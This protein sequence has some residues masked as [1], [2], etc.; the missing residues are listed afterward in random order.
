MLYAWKSKSDDS[1]VKI[2]T[3]NQTGFEKV[4]M[5]YQDLWYLIVQIFRPR[6]YDM[7]MNM[8]REKGERYGAKVYDQG[9]A[10]NLFKFVAGKLGYM[11]NRSVPWI[12]FESTDSKLMRRDHIKEYLNNA[13]E[14]ALFGVGRSTLYSA[15]VPHNMDAESVG[16]GVLVPM[17][18]EFKD[19]VVFDVVHP[20]EAYIGTDQFGDVNVFHRCPLK[21]TRMKAQ[22]LFGK[23][24]LP[25]TWYNEDGELKALVHEDK[26]IWAVY[27]NEDRNNN[28]K[29]ATDNRY[30][31]FCI[32]KGGG[33]QKSKLVYKSGRPYFPTC[34]RTGRESG[35]A[36][37]TSTAADCLTSALV[38]NK[39]GEK[40]VEAAHKAV[41]PAKIA[42]KSLQSALRT[43]HGGRAGSTIWADDI[44]KEGVKLF[45]DRLNWPVTDAQLVRIDEQM[46]DRMFIRFFEML[47]AGD[48]KSRT[49]Y[50]VSQMMAEKATL[51]STM[52]DTLEEE[53]LE[54]NI[55]IVVAEEARAGRMP[56]VPPE[57]VESKGK[58]SVRYLGPLAQLQRS[59]LR[60][61]GTI[62][63]LGI[64]EQMMAMNEKVGWVFN[65]QQMAEDVTIAQGLPQ[66]L[67]TSDEEQEAMERGVQ[68][69]QRMEQ[70]AQMLEVAGKA[71][72][73][74]GKAPEEGST[75]AEAI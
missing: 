71:S 11:V 51:M 56:P 63:A 41:D 15:L 5:H 14:Q 32:L 53:D 9:P 67:I 46:K 21:L 52:V 26:Y 13:A 12:Q 23:E 47:N 69:Q 72:P 55:A 39:L 31:V 1:I 3:G 29:L 16:T 70:Q 48:I 60:S 73:G 24:K 50:E 28:S 37:G 75:L 34:Y 18:D 6:R 49:A 27:P 33:R 68:E 57:L 38:T 74:L 66:R 22:L 65:W 62:D 59:L 40:G 54:P 45:Q 58:I 2:V 19:R 25:S 4:R 44:N 17:I 36:Y 7:L 61:R 43:A 30:I 8:D 64:I 42:S 35:A 10:N 20:N